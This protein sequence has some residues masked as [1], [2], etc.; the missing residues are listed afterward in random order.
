MIREAFTPSGAEVARAREV[1][2][3]FATASETGGGTFVLAEHA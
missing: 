1:L 2:Q 3:G